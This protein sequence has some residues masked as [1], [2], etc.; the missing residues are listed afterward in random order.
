MAELKTHMKSGVHVLISIQ[1][2]LS[3]R[4]RAVVSSAALPFAQQAAPISRPTRM[5]DRD[6]TASVCATA[7]VLFSCSGSIGSLFFL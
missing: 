6:K 1:I 3:Q 7:D 4:V 5:A 2:P